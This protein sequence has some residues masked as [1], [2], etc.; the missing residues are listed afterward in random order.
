M[1]VRTTIQQVIATF[2]LCLLGR[3]AHVYPLLS[4]VN[5]YRS[6]RRG[7]GLTLGLRARFGSK[8]QGLGDRKTISA[9]S[10]IGAA[11]LERTH[12]KQQKDK[13]ADSDKAQEKEVVIIDDDGDV[14]KVAVVGEDEGFDSCSNRVSLVP[15][16]ESA[17]HS[18]CALISDKIS[19]PS[20]LSQQHFDDH[21]FVTSRQGQGIA[22]GQG[23]GLE[24]DQTLLQELAREQAISSSAVVVAS[25]SG[26][27]PHDCVYPDH[28][29]NVPSVSHHG[30]SV[31]DRKGNVDV[32]GNKNGNDDGNDVPVS[33]INDAQKILDYNKCDQVPQQQQPAVV[34]AK[35]YLIPWN[36]MHMI[37]FSGIVSWCYSLTRPY[38][39]IPH[40][41]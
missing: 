19:P 24:L 36:T 29:P 9:S 11:A 15:V 10:S 17:S 38:H 37:F 26:S 23:Q 8:G 25:V 12:Q 18:S 21:S 39:T 34:S 20:A 31:G 5:A 27:S 2:C 30:G 22:Q 14:D 7:L 4:S 32:E 16:D 40:P 1:C 33:I 6:W 13:G 28:S 3:A 35:R 41:P